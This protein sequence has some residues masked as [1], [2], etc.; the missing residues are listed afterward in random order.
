MTAPRTVVP[1]SGWR[2]CGQ[3]GKVKTAEEYDGE[4]VV[5][6]PCLTAP[7]PKPKVSRAV[8]TRRAAASPVPP[9]PPGPRQPLLGT[10][11]SGDLEVRERRAK[12]MAQEV[13]VEHY[14]EEYELLL[15]SA[16][17]AEGLRVS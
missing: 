8:V 15:Q 14:P 2:K 9:A 16:R 1:V 10:I 6:T 7:A 12:R 4:A 5:C 17:K 3:C 11:G 13:L